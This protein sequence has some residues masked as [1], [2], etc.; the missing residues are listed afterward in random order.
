L[1]TLLR[2][3]GS[4]FYLSDVLIRQERAW[5]EPFLRQINAPQ[6]TLSDHLSQLQSVVSVQ[7]SFD[8]FSVALR[9]HKQRE[10][11]RIGVRDLLPSVTVEETVRELTALAEA[12]L[13]A[14]Y[15][16]C[17]AEVGKDF[18]SLLLLPRQR[19]S[20]WL[21][22]HRDGKLGGQELN[23]GSD[24]DVIFLYEEE[25]AKVPAAGKAKRRQESFS[26]ATEEQRS[27]PVWAIACEEAYPSARISERNQVFREDP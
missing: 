11:L 5:P 3:L 6:K 7:K 27:P 1:P 26:P 22:G 17:R 18:G 10:H 8:E 12:S 13:E 20:E 14:T 2:L 19:N 4:S 15:R 16:F 25:K 9:R 23:F 21:C 24:I